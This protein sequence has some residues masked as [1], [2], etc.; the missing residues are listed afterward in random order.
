M[1]MS[2]SDERAI[3][4]LGLHLLGGGGDFVGRSKLTKQT[5]ITP[6]GLGMPIKFNVTTVLCD[7]L[8][9]AKKKV[10]NQGELSLQL[11]TNRSLQ[12]LVELGSK[13]MQR[14]H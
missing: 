9:Y 13:F 2:F 14:F 10:K 4:V 11:H 5:S 8:W 6:M 7:F 3:I 12:S 1:K